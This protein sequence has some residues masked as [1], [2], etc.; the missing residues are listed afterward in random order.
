MMNRKRMKWEE[1]GKRTHTLMVGEGE[2]RKRTKSTKTN[3]NSPLGDSHC[4]HLSLHS[5]HRTLHPNPITLSELHSYSALAL[6][7]SRSIIKWI[8]TLDWPNQCHSLGLCLFSFQALFCAI[9]LLQSHIEN[10][11]FNR[12]NSSRE[13]DQDMRV[14]SI[15]SWDIMEHDYEEKEK[16]NRN[17]QGLYD[18]GWKVMIKTWIWS[19]DIELWFYHLDSI[20]SMR[21]TCVP[22]LSW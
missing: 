15:D 22:S 7:S 21:S 17:H 4:K 2:E 5:Q 18:I 1:K 19:M 8:S 10:K 3:Q 11:T 16:T 12:Y 20:D 9:S 14:G 13:H 6:L